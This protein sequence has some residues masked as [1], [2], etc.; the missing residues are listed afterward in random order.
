MMK[1]IRKVMKKVTLK[2]SKTY[3]NS[4]HREVAQY[5]AEQIIAINESTASEHTH[6]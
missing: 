5:T 4:Y 3:H 1:I 6:F 2:C